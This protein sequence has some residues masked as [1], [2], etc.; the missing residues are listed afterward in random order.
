MAL[1]KT[2][3]ERR[4][5]T[6]AG[7][8]TG[9]R[10]GVA[11]AIKEN[12]ELIKIAAPDLPDSS[13]LTN[14][15]YREFA[16]EAIEERSIGGVQLAD[17]NE[18]AKASQDFQNFLKNK[19]AESLEEIV[20]TTEQVNTIASTA[21]DAV[22]S[23]TGGYVVDS[24]WNRGVRIGKGA[25]NWALSDEE[26]AFAAPTART[27][28][29]EVTTQLTEL[30]QERP[31]IAILLDD[32]TMKKIETEVHESV[33]HSINKTDPPKI[34]KLDAVEVLP[35]DEAKRAGIYNQ[36]GSVVYEQTRDKITETIEE[37]K[38]AARN[39]G[40]KGFLFRIAEAID[41]FLGTNLAGMLAG[42]AGVKIPKDHEVRNAAR[43]VAK[44]SQNV[45]SEHAANMS[46]DDLIDEVR[47]TTREELEKHREH[48]AAFTDEQLDELAARSAQ[49]ISDNY[50]RI[51]RIA[52]ARTVAAN[53]AAEKERE[54]ANDAGITNPTDTKDIKAHEAVKLLEGALA[55]NDTS[56]S[57]GAES[58]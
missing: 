2:Q 29:T 11:S 7:V 22:V 3:T 50:D 26:N 45:V 46:K 35:V 38:E 41:S 12:Y 39:N 8:E 44:T 34:D 30:S 28:S 6:I 43:V 10:D 54:P 32:S 31:D 57:R 14:D 27:F 25:I 16:R 21:G 33:V 17:I 55:K 23:R 40:F 4:N 36:F 5:S 52:N 20:P 15:D 58:N 9:F 18:R 49:G 48:Y 1:T 51:P 47:T 24:L 53:A 56:M 42:F 37:K 13:T 19:N